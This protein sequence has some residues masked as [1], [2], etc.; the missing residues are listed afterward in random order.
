MILDY[1]RLNIV[2]AKLEPLKA[3]DL[4]RR[5]ERKN[6]RFP[7]KRISIFFLDFRD[8]TVSID[9]KKKIGEKRSKYIPDSIVNRFPSR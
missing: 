4:S 9:N 8:D 5:L 2:D 3:R 7:Q 1:S 6:K